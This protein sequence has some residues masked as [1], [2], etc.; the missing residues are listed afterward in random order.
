[1]KRVSHLLLAFIFIS[2]AGCASSRQVKNDPVVGSWAYSVEAPEATYTGTLTITRVN[3]EY[4]ARMESD[5]EIGALTVSNVQ[6]VE[7]NLTFEVQGPQSG[8][9]KA[10]VAIEEATLVGKVDNLTYGAVGMPIV[11]QRKPAE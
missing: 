8:H 10:A 9:L 2:L 6:V 4:A 1:M 3:D 5:Q 11:A 7:D